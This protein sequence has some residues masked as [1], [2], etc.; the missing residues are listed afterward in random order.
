MIDVK[1]NVEIGRLMSE[2]E[3]KR[4]FEYKWQK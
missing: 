4:S 3:S 2:G 1:I